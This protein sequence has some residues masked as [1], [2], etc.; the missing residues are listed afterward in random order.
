MTRR[1]ILMRHAKSSWKD[2]SLADHD[3]PLNARG[4]SDAA[5]VAARLL[6]LGWVPQKVTSSDAKR[7]RQTW[8]GMAKVLPDG[9]EA[10]FTP[11]LYLAG[12]DSI[13]AESRSWDTAIGTVL[14][15]GHNPGWEEALSHLTG[16]D[17]GMTTANAAL[18]IGRGASWA[19]ALS[20]PWQL[21]DLI[22]PRELA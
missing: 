21:E 19:E 18:L 14:T 17:D 8:K 5:R 13:R 11:E 9:I 6:E 1:L 12:L 10:R 3:R 7:T 15:L 22:R 16:R 4:K 2:L 20:G